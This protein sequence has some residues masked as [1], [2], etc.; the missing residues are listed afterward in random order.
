MSLHRNYNI[1]KA[2]KNIDIREVVEN[3]LGVKLPD[4]R[5][6]QIICPFHNEDHGS[7]TI[8]PETNSFYCFGC[9]AGRGGSDTIAFIEK[10]K[11]WERKEAFYYLKTHYLKN[12]DISENHQ[13]EETIFEE[14]RLSEDL[15]EWL[16]NRGLTEET[17]ARFGLTCFEDKNS[18]RWLGIPIFNE[19]GKIV[20]FKIRRD[21]IKEDPNLVKYKWLKAGT[22]QTLFPINCI[23]YENEELYLVEGELDA[24]LLHQEGYNSLTNT[25]GGTTLWKDEWIEIVKRF[26]KIYLIPD[27]DESGEKWKRN[28][29]EKLEYVHNDIYIIEIPFGKDV[30]EFYQKGGDLRDLLNNGQ[31]KEI[32]KSFKTIKE[33]LKTEYNEPSFLINKLIPHP[34]LTVISGYPESGKTWVILGLAKSIAEGS[35]FL[36]EDFKAEKGNVGIIEEENGEKELQRR[37]KMLNFKEDLPI[38]VLSQKGLK[39]DDKKIIEFLLEEAEINKI[40]VLIFDPFIAFHSLSENSAEEMQRVMECFSEFQK[41]GI[42]VI[43]THHHRKQLGWTKSAPSQALRG[44]SVLFGRVDCHLAIE[45]K[46]ELDNGNGFEVVVIQEKLRNGKKIK[47]FELRIFENVDGFMEFQYLGEFQE[48][49]LKIEKAKEIILN[50]LEEGSKTKTEII[51]VLIQENI[52]QRTGENALKE[53]IESQKIK[54]QRVGKQKI[55]ELKKDDELSLLEL[56]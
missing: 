44:S 16:K 15:L 20:N 43:F 8:F 23:D 48:E 54:A 4:K 7:F 37:F 2:I 34:S 38:F 6:P 5:R 25:G 33:I 3:E 31:V 12:F 39:I 30:T 52:G 19:S 36:I 14:K 32:S 22:K 17:I 21:P 28:L 1:I 55:F 24:I 49:K 35:F 40:K 29:L 10:L 41:Y 56:T 47:P 53:L 27:R 13:Y 9:G 18:N 45:K 50:L 11:G 51:N 26:K 42:S 46:K